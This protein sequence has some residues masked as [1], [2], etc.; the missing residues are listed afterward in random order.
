MPNMSASESSHED[1]EIEDPVD[2]SDGLKFSTPRLKNDT[3]SALHPAEHSK[4][5]STD[6]DCQDV[7]GRFVF[8]LCCDLQRSNMED[9]QSYSQPMPL[10]RTRFFIQQRLQGM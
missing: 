8:R 3:K 6:F 9:P 7:R 5:F 10:L 4:C 2:Q 1:K